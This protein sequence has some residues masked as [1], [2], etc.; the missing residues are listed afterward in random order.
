MRSVLWPMVG[1]LLLLAHGAAADEPA[2]LGP[3]FQCASIKADVLATVIC[4]DPA[5]SRLDLAFA[6]AYQSLKQQLGPAGA[7]ALVQ[8]DLAF[9]ATVRDACHLPPPGSLA[10][11]PSPNAVQCVQ[12]LYE[13]QRSGWVARLTG[14]A[15]EEAERP[16]EQHLV[17]QQDLQ[18]A[19]YLPAS[20]AVDGVYGSGAR[21]AIAKWQ[22]AHGEVADGVM[23]DATAAAL[24]AAVPDSEGAPDGAKVAEAPPMRQSVTQANMDP[25]PSAGKPLEMATCA[26]YLRATPEMQQGPLMELVIWPVMQGLDRADLLRGCRSA[27]Q[28]TRLDSPGNQRFIA[29]MCRGEPGQMLSSLSQALYGIDRAIAKSGFGDGCQ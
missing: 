20:A 3:S 12:G 14:A 15:R 1:G 16:L 2:A 17:L 28:D 9:L 18:K 21:A 13:K 22:A 11:A 6:Q 24:A 19:G 7:S 26:D 25:I 29:Q 4:S 23:S 5:L 8:E 27:I 10:P